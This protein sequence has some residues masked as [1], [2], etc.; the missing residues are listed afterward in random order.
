MATMS[1]RP[2]HSTDDWFGIFMGAAVIC[3]A[4]AFLAFLY[5]KTGTGHLGSYSVTVRLPNVE[6]LDIGKDVRIGGVKVGSVSGL[7]LDPTTY[8]PKVTV[9][10]RDDLSLPV[11]STATV[12]STFMGETYLVITPGHR[13][14]IVLPGGA[15]GPVRPEPRAPGA[16][17]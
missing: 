6:G 14:R 3:V 5:A 4:L 12:A 8:S 1:G 13:N 9:T 15:F 11:D 10:I 17:T 16:G 2:P 7:S